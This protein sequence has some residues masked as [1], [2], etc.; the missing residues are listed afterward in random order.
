MSRTIFHFY[1][2]LLNAYRKYKANESAET[3]QSLINRINRVPETDPEILQ[4]FKKG[5]SFEDAVLKNKPSDIDPELIEQVKKLLPAKYKTQQKLSFQYRNIHFYGYADVVGDNRVIDL[6]S[7]SLHK[8]GRHDFN[9]QNLYLYALRNMGFRQMEYIICDF[10]EVYQE[11]YEIESYDF[12]PLLAKMEE[13]ATF[14]LDN[15]DRIRD[16]KIMSEQKPDLFG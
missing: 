1:P 2:T 7:T 8:P 6:K 14:V 3:F 13:F 5:I 9:F 15:K 12:E 16:Q 11:I 4:K 10:Q